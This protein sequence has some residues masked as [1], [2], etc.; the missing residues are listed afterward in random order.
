MNLC[1]LC[2]LTWNR[3]RGALKRVRHIIKGGLCVCSEKSYSISY[4]I[5]VGDSLREMKKFYEV[6]FCF[7]R[8]IFG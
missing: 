2:V 7:E 3:E 5:T 4:L 8:R 6:F 1:M